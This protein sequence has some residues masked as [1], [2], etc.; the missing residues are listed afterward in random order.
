MSAIW[1]PWHGC[2]KISEGCKNCYVYR[3]DAKYD[4]DSSLPYKTQSFDL[5]VKRKRDGNYKIESG[6]TVFACMTSDFFL[7]AADPWRE[8]AWSY[9]KERSDL[10][11]FI[12]TK[13]IS[14]YEVCL[15]KDIGEGYENV[16]VCA[17]CENQKRADE[18]LPLLISLPIKHRMIIHEPMLESINIEKYLKTGK[19]EQ[20][21]CGGESGP[22]ARECNYDW[23]L[24][25]REQCLRYNVP[26]YFKQTG[27]N[28][29]KD[30]RRYRV[31]RKFQHSQARKAGIN[32]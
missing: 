17:T 30:G 24:F 20:V 13:R 7:D 26:F 27:A 2:T 9:I 18:R 28:F 4:L 11:F 6:E 21:T 5:P 32:T 19:I 15:P 16:T 23:I 8:R 31:P 1:N 25:A 29:I 22:A 3:R 14:R 12:I 10:N